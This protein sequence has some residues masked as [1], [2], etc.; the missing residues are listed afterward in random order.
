MVTTESSTTK[1]MKCGEWLSPM[2][3]RQHHHSFHRE[4]P[5][6]KF[7][8]CCKRY[9]LIFRKKQVSTAAKHTKLN[10]PRNVNCV[11]FECKCG[12]GSARRVIYASF[13]YQTNILYKVPATEEHC[14]FFTG[15]R[16]APLIDLFHFE[17]HYTTAAA[18]HAGRCSHCR[19]EEQLC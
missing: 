7:Y 1:T 8:H 17:S 11:I 19:A 5:P 4:V 3:D 10:A 2:D 9:V 12:G 18:K 15:I 14:S 16:T 13:N 6:E